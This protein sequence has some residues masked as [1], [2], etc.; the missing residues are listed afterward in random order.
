MN[1][2]ILAFT[3]SI[4]DFGAG[5][6]AEFQWRHTRKIFRANLESTQTMFRNWI[7]RDAQVASQVQAAM[8]AIW[9]FTPESASKAP[10]T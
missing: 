10:H 1:Q 4:Q 5:P 8:E 3:G 6:A 2:P 7:E 9:S